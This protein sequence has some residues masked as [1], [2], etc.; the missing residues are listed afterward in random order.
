[1]P[2]T[3]RVP[4]RL[5]DIQPLL[6]LAPLASAHAAEIDRFDGLVNRRVR[7]R[8]GARAEV[9]G[10]GCGG[11]VVGVAEAGAPVREVGGDDPGGV[12]VGEVGAE[13]GGELAFGGGGGVADHD[14]HERGEGGAVVGAEGTGEGFVDVGEVHF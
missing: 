13:D 11:L 7:W 1:M 8:F 2:S 12:R 6:V 9:G 10:R 4:R 5:Q 3:H 14:G